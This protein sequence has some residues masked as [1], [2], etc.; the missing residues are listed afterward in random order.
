MKCKDAVR[1]SFLA[2]AL[3]ML[4]AGSAA[5]A[6]DTSSLINQ[7]LDQPVKVQFDTVLPEAMNQIAR[8][9]G[10]RVEAEQGVWDI[11]PW[12]QQT[13][14]QAKIENPIRQESIFGPDRH[15]R[16]RRA[17][18]KRIVTEGQTRGDIADREGERTQ[19][20]VLT[21]RAVAEDIVSGPQ[22]LAKDRSAAPNLE[23]QRSQR[24]EL[25]K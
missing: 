21:L 10:V 14:I 9:T 5:I 2:A 19:F 8:S 25:G 11:L 12:G 16:P 22:R 4:C 15:D 17:R 6:Q 18:L 13:N 1:R 3:M 7:A 24:A 20:C 23:Y